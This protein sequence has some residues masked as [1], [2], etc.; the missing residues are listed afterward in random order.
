MMMI[1]LGLQTRGRRA[2]PA[3]AR[4]PGARINAKRGYGSAKAAVLIP[5]RSL[6]QQRLLNQLLYI[7]PPLVCV[8]L[9]SS[10][11]QSPLVCV[12]LLSKINNT[13]LNYYD[14]MQ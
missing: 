12:A 11:I 10:Y 3:S 1:D 14:R 7:S 9:L 4:S 6:R 8:A 5:R 2:F 13:Y